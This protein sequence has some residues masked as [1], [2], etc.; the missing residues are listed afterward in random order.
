MVDGNDADELN[1]GAVPIRETKTK[2]I[3]IKNIS[4]HSKLRIDNIFLDLLQ[5][6]PFSFGNIEFPIYINPG[7]SFTLNISFNPMNKVRSYAVLLSIQYSDSTMAANPNNII[8]LLLRGVVLFPASDIDLPNVLVFGQ[9]TEGQSL[10]KEFE[11]SN[12][13]ETYLTIDS[14]VAAGE[15]AS[16][17]TIKDKNFPVR[18][19][20][21]DI[22]LCTVTFKA[23]GTG[24]KDAKLLVYTSDLFGS[25]ADGASEIILY[26]E[27]KKAEDN[28]IGVTKLDEI[29]TVYNLSQNYPNPFNPTTK[30]EYSLPEASRVRLSVYNNLGQQV[31]SLVNEYQA[32]GRYIVEFNAMNLPSGIYFYRI[33]SDNFSAVKKMMLVK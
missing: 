23:S 18:L 11:I 31:I 21:E 25:N 32:T 14:I 10:T 5:N 12:Y 20:I 4:K 15:D 7:E 26:A 19:G 22:Y 13:G 30:I 29:P 24:F 1:F 16:A 27:S 6:Q 2:Q 28:T 17:F 8:Q 3:E 9:V 33:Q